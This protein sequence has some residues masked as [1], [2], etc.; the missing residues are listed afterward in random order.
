MDAHVF[1]RLCDALA[2]LLSGARLEKIQ[3]PAPGVHAFTFYARRRKE[4]LFLRADRRTPFLFLSPERQST[5]RHPDAPVMRLRKH[6]AG[7]RVAA[8]LPDW[9]AR[10]LSLLFRGGSEY[11][12][13]APPETWLVLDLREGPRLLLGASPDMPVEPLWPEPEELAEA[14][15]DEN[16][17]NWPVLTPA[18]RRTLPHLEPLEQQALLADL[19]VGGGDLFAYA[20]EEH[21]ENGAPRSVDPEI[22]AWP[23]PEPLRRGRRERVFEDPLAAAAEVGGMLVLGGLARTAQAQNAN[24]HK[25]EEERLA[26]ILKKLD[27]EEQ[28]LRDM[29]MM[30]EQALAL[31]AN[32][33]RFAPEAKAPE[34]V[35]PAPDGRDAPLRIS[36]DPRL[37]VREN[38][39]ALFHTAARGERG[40]AFLEQRRSR[41]LR[42]RRLAG[43]AAQAALLGVPAAPTAPEMGSNRPAGR[44]PK[45]VQAFVSSD[46]LVIL[47]GRDAKGNWALLKVA[48]SYDLWMH[49][50]G[51]PGSHVVVRRFFAGQEI[52]ERTLRE[53]GG[54]AAAKSWQRDSEY[55]H[56]LC[57]EVRHVRPL[58]GAAPGTVRVDKAAQTF[59]ATVDAGLEQRLA[60]PD[61]A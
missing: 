44:L 1:R 23:L 25:R 5:G 18:L 46:G 55:A 13:S 9:P 3:S 14:C 7:R 6:L 53:A 48:A 31:Q 50:E 33:W 8:C 29:R 57:A 54:L 20:P 21:G 15:A 58:R 32:L 22:F 16:W 10:R 35:V 61:E 34:A 52:P 59:R 4:H 39:A 36:L 49:V 30:R 43:D 37:T 60:L 51:G 45:G 27:A 26:R 42:E 17:R 11:P 28:R 19:T 38:M 24:P 40:L 56:I 41:L 12:E 47:R 2:P